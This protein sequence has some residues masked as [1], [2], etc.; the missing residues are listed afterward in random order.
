MH[1]TLLSRLP[2]L[3]NGVLAIHGIPQAQWHKGNFHLIL[4]SLLTCGIFLEVV[5]FSPPATERELTFQHALVSASA[6]CGSGSR[7]LMR[8]LSLQQWTER[9]GR[10]S[11]S[12]KEISNTQST[13][14][15]KFNHM[16]SMQPREK[17]TFRHNSET[18]PQTWMF[19]FPCLSLLKSS[20]K[21]Y[22]KGYPYLP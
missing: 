6:L 8:L 15:S 4:P 3:L 7:W 2:R 11:G 13:T 17:P 12:P 1:I 5:V 18:T 16:F 21:K 19:S 20:K 22:M 14:S 9:A 10:S